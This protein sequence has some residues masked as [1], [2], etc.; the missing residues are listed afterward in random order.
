MGN[1]ALRS[2]IWNDDDHDNGDDDNDNDNDDNDD[3]YTIHLTKIYF[4]MET[5]KV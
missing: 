3:S 5:L 1:P 4:C 2:D